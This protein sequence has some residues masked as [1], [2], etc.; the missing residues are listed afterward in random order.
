MLLTGQPPVNKLSWTL[1]HKNQFKMDQR[2]KY[3]GKTIK[4]SKGNIGV[5]LHDRRVY[6]GF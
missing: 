5:N 3:K 2:A 1:T 6:K 4:L